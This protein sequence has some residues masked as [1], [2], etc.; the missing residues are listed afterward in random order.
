[1]E[2]NKTQPRANMTNQNDLDLR[3]ETQVSSTG[4]KHKKENDSLE[5]G[6]LRKAS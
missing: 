2:I 4:K 6:D 5:L 3:R 1:M